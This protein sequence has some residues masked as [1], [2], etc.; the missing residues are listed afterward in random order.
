MNDKNMRKSGLRD[1][2]VINANSVA[3]LGKNEPVRMYILMKIAEALDCT[4]KDL[5]VTIKD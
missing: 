1:K 5:F 4:V 3:K 2:T